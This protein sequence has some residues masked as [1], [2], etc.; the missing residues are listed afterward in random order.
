MWGSRESD[1]YRWHDGLKGLKSVM[2][3]HLETAASYFFRCTHMLSYGAAY[4][5]SKDMKDNHKIYCDFLN[6][7]EN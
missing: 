4:K 2:P 6:V 1:Y 3:H 5:L 7:V